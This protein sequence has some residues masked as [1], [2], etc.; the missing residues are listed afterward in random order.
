M[1]RVVHA[2]A[3]GTQRE[4]LMRSVRKPAPSD[5]FIETETGSSLGKME[6]SR[7]GIK[8]GTAATI[9]SKTA[10][11]ESTATANTKLH[12]SMATLGADGMDP[13]A[14]QKSTANANAKQD[15]ATAN[16]VVAD[17]SEIKQHPCQDGDPLCA[18]SAA[19]K[20]ALDAMPKDE[21]EQELHLWWL[22][23]P[24]G[25]RLLL[26][27]GLA[28]FVLAFLCICAGGVHAALDK[29]N[30]PKESAKEEVGDNWAEG[31]GVYLDS[32]L[33]SIDF[34]EKVPTSNE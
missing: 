23:T 7:N 24:L 28:I 1:P 13:S 16:A 17:P 11:H 9:E 22:R 8:A 34:A 18:G 14:T 25:D 27:L 31:E 6:V 26:R 29:R 32:G 5:G 2:D 15:P 20:V 10:S 4:M 12:E 33:D 3:P 19:G 21:I 30:G